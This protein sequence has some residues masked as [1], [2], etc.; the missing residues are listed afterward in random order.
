[1]EV[2]SECAIDL[3][4]QIAAVDEALSRK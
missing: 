1:L 2:T 3:D 4:A